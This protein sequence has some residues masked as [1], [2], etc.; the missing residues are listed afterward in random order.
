MDWYC[1]YG[2]A[3][4]DLSGHISSVL[5][6]A[7]FITDAEDAALADGWKLSYATFKATT[8]QLAYLEIMGRI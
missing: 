4:N 2:I 1:V 5:I 3:P 8:M 7:D 6:K